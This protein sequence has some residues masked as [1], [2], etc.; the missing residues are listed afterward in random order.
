[1]AFSASSI[2]ESPCL[3]L[4]F[5][6]L[7]GGVRAREA[8]LHI[9]AARTG[10]RILD[11][12]CGP[13]YYLSQLPSVEYHGFD[14]DQRYIDHARSQ[15]AERGTFHCELF[16]EKHVEHLGKFDGVL[17]MGL[18]HHLDDLSANR[19]LGLISKSLV[20]GGRVVALDTV[21]HDR[22]SRFS[23]WLAQNDRGK[24]VRRPEAFQALGK[25]WFSSVKGRVTEDPWSPSVYYLMVLR[26][27]LGLSPAE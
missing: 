19:L 22:Q 24:H 17:L 2:L 25:Q 18:L 8:S 6:R 3:Y 1:M 10:E 5:Q 23:R 14:T 27:P 13:A 11:V 7:V 26:S 16:T 9:L 15:F 12:G 21:V 20:P 4:S